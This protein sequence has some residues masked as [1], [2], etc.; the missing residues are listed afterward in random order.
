[1]FATVTALLLAVPL[2]SATQRAVQDAPD[3]DTAADIILQSYSDLGHPAVD[4]LVTG[5]QGHYR[6]ESTV[7]PLGPI[8]TSGGPQRTQNAARTFFSQLEGEPFH[9][10]TF[11]N[12][13]A[14]YHQTRLHAAVPE[15]SPND[16]FTEVDL[17]L[18]LKSSKPVQFST[19]FNN[20]GASPLP[21]E[22]VSLSAAIADPFSQ[23][24][25]FSLSLTSTPDPSDFAAVSTTWQRQTLSGTTTLTAAYSEASASV[26]SIE[27]DSWTLL[28]SAQ[29][30]FGTHWSVALN[31]RRSNS[32][33]QFGG[34][35]ANLSEANFT[36]T[37][38]LQIDRSDTW[39][40]GQSVL[41]LIASPG[42][43]TSDN[44]DRAF[45]TLRPGAEATYVI[46]RG[47]LRHKVT[48]P[49]DLALDISLR[50]QISSAPLL[51]PDQLSLG[52]VAG[53]RS[54][55]EFSQLGDH[56]FI[57]QTELS[58]PIITFAESLKVRPAL[59]V[60]YGVVHDDVTGSQSHGAAAGP[61]LRARWNSAD[62]YLAAG[63]G[64]DQS[65]QQ[66]HASLRYS[67]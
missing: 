58:L 50:S 13:L 18:D 17:N 28:A 6:T 9:L 46:A 59:F 55:S 51:Q 26:R 21:R 14:R 63:F 53:V 39:E 66:V 33:L 34:D 61:V 41:S 54:R 32:S 11:E 40:N 65:D 8:T 10:P 3:A 5:T 15:L 24:G 35:L 49:A 2:P 52:G 36:D 44:S 57:A 27:I 23:P 31:Y 37:F 29:Q 64:L 42:S 43:I 7:L 4:V 45:D 60:D 38:Q 20:F 56:G 48:L 12:A 30:S 19:A 22:R 16:A 25:S 67:F 62:V 47:A 1:M